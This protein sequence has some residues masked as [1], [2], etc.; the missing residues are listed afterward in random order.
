VQG[1]IIHVG[2]RLG[3]GATFG[4]RVSSKALPADDARYVV[5]RIVRA[6]K[7][8]RA[9]GSTFGEWADGQSDARLESLIGIGVAREREPAEA[10]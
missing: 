4:R 9:P 5:E 10:A 7:G 1:F 3:E 2:G 6:Y 8:E